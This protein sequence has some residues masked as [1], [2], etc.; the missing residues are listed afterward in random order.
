MPQSDEIKKKLEELRARTNVVTQPPVTPVGAE[1][2]KNVQDML[3]A[4]RLRSTGSAAPQDKD[5]GFL[6]AAAQRLGRPLDSIENFAIKTGIGAGVVPLMRAAQ[7]AFQDVPAAL[8]DPALELVGISEGPTENFTKALARGKAPSE[9]LPGQAFVDFAT[10]NAP[11]VKMGIVAPDTMKGIA[12]LGIDVV[13]DAANVIPAGAAAKTIKAIKKGSKT[14]ANLDKTVDSGEAL[15]KIISEEVPGKI[16]DDIAADSADKIG[17]IVGPDVAKVIVSDNPIAP[18]MTLEM[19]NRLATAMEKVMKARGLKHDPTKRIS[20]DETGE[21]LEKNII[22]FAD[23]EKAG[24]SMQDEMAMALLGEIS[25]SGR[26][27]QRW[28]TVVKRA[29]IQAQGKG[30]VAE[31]AK[32]FLKNRDK[33][34]KAVTENGLNKPRRFIQIW[35]GLLVSQIAT[36]VRNIWTQGARSGTEIVDRGFQFGL[37]ALGSLVSGHRRKEVYHSFNELKDAMK[38]AVDLT[39]K[40][41][42]IR[43][44]TDVVRD[45]FGKAVKGAKEGSAE[46]ISNQVLDL[47]PAQ[48]RKLFKSFSQD[49]EL[50]EKKFADVF[51]RNLPGNILNQFQERLFRNAGFIASLKGKARRSGQDFDNLLKTGNLHLLKKKDVEAAVEDALE[52]T[53]AKD[54]Q[55][56]GLG[57]LVVQFSKH[58][59]TA[60]LLPFGRFLSN[61]T[62]FLYEHSPA[63][64]PRL[65][66]IS[67]KEGAVNTRELSKMVSGSLMFGAAMD[68]RNSEFAGEKWYEIDL[69]V[70][71]ADGKNKFVDA[72]AFSPFS[73]YLYLAEFFKRFHTQKTN[74]EA[75]KEFFQGA[76]GTNFRGGTAIRAIDELVTA[77]SQASGPE[78]LDVNNQTFK[79]LSGVAGEFFGG[80]ATPFQPVKD[81][82]AHF[83]ESEKIVRERRTVESKAGVAT[84]LI[85]P[86]AE[87]IPFASQALGL[88]EVRLPTREG[89]LLRNDPLFRQIVGV[90]TKRKT[91]IEREL[92]RLRFTRSEIL[93][94]TGNSDFDRV[95]ASIMGP[96]VERGITALMKNPSYKEAGDGLKAL[97]M[98]Q[99]LAGTRRAAVAKARELRPEDFIKQVLKQGGRRKREAVDEILKEKGIDKK[100][101]IQD[102][103][104]ELRDRSGSNP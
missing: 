22:T 96:L 23:L 78:G 19:N 74:P 12:K 89:P 49:V 15:K 21:L 32:R 39:I 54:P 51:V 67:M 56:G 63:A 75:F 82:V 61:S 8:I 10:E 86:T 62:R 46:A 1:P 102:K 59:L 41:G 38:M 90:T 69:G 50:G 7:F 66:S 14:V 33:V 3:Q 40:S 87:R 71:D 43:K 20:I 16:A 73:S 34:T 64:L 98:K 11:A 36:A 29:K 42:G 13:A 2:N 31:A 104:K 37:D 91:D 95:T 68:F 70:K 101:L 103:L 93:P 45:K 99:A 92:D 5:P 26:R 57:D 65:M 25:D 55:R 58:P 44:G 30:E 60:T 27:L 17:D 6:E 97:M 35:K 77:A 79:A 28:S 88:P 24:M 80:F 9:T 4:L 100:Q 48:Q 18:S 94:S 84:P 52:L 76:L 85:S 72:R 47:F 53:F 81:A 83:D